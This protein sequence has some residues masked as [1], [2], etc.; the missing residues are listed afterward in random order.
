MNILH[1]TGRNHIDR[2]LYHNLGR[3]LRH[4]QAH[5]ILRESPL[6]GRGVRRQHVEHKR[7]DGR[8][9]GEVAYVREEIAHALHGQKDVLLHPMVFEAQ[10]LEVRTHQRKFVPERQILIPESVPFPRQ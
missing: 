10:V 1:T 2:I 6:L 4:L 7:L 5:N 9:Q 8:E 3:V